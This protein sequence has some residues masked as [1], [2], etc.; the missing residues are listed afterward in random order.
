MQTRADF[1]MCCYESST[2]Q[3]QRRWRKKSR[4]VRDCKVVE[5]GIFLELRDFERY[6]LLVSSN[7]SVSCLSSNPT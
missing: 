1:C 7:L 6:E 5:D 2:R 4:R 3:I